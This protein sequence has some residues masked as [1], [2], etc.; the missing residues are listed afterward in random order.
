LANSIIIYW[1]ILREP[2]S[3]RK[4]QTNQLYQRCVK[5]PYTLTGFFYSIQ[6]SC[7]RNGRR[8]VLATNE[9]LLFC[10]YIGSLMEY[11]MIIWWI[12]SFRA[13]QI[14]EPFWASLKNKNRTTFKLPPIRIY[15]TIVQDLIREVPSL[16]VGC[17][18]NTHVTTSYDDSYAK[19]SY[20]LD[21]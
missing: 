10:Y 11:S 14:R 1:V 8:F 17:Y 12:L 16:L 9:H 6:G 20:R 15:P 21:I 4:A 7:C 3:Q 18:R 5:S 13:H 2:L 19:H